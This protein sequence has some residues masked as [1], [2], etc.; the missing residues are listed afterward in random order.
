MKSIPKPH[1]ATVRTKLPAKRKAPPGPSPAHEILVP[2]DFSKSSQET[3]RHAVLLAKVMPG[4]ITLLHVE[5]PQDFSEA[6]GGLPGT[7]MAGRTV[8]PKPAGPRLEALARRAVPAALAGEIL[9]RPGAAGEVVVTVAKERRSSLIIVAT[10][11]YSGLQR[12]LLGSTAEHIVRHCPCP[13]LTVRRPAL[14]KRRADGAASA[15]RIKSI[16]APVDLSSPSRQ[17]SG[18]AA[19]LA[20]QLGAQLTLLHVVPPLT[21]TRRRPLDT[22]R[23]NARAAEGAEAAL[24]EL[25]QQTPVAP[26]LHKTAKPVQ[27]RVV[28]GHAPDE[29]LREAK[30]TAVDLLVIATHG[31][32]G[33]GRI[34]LGST[35]EN[36]VRHAPCPVLVVR[37]AKAV[38]KSWYNPLIF[39]PVSPFLP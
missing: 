15:V 18:Y 2:I 20:G 24:A 25:V 33:L 29:I 36:I 34:L 6:S 17:A 5:A 28:F 9:V 39:F 31:R 23:L 38:K 4:K 32:G 21:T 10:H 1:P 13:V 12:V 27:T 30:E 37:R 19:T 7:I 35:A 8:A 16:L 11:G 22:S 3:L 26:H 14:R